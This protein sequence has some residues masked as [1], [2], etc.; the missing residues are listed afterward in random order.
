MAMMVSQS[1]GLSPEYQR[2]YDDQLLSYAKPQ[3]VTAQFAQ[4][5]PF[6]KNKGATSIRFF[7]PSAPDRTRVS[8]LTNEG[9]PLAQFSEIAYTGID[10]S[11]AQ[12]G[13][14]VKISDIVS[15]T[16]LF[17]TLDQSV[18]VMGE[19]AGVDADFR[20]ISQVVTGT[21]SA[22]KRYGSLAASNAAAGKLTIK[23][24]LASYTRLTVTKAKKPEGR[25]YAAILS[26]QQAYDIMDD[27]K[28]IDAGVRGNNKGLF[29]GEIGRWYGNRILVTTEPFIEAVGSE[30]TYNSAGA[31]YVAL[32]LGRESLG[33]CIMAGQSPFSPQIIVNDK[34]DSG[35]PLKQFMTAGWKAYWATVMLN[36]LWA[37]TLRSTST[38]A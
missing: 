12:Y 32:V 38:F 8:Q 37:V 18:R 28:F 26:P 17:D 19:D 9:V 35:N 24:L 25:E 21:N 16:D 34:A 36:D 13:E 1:S 10:V 14:A 6:P 5:K 23:D 3:I 31:M 7:R 20:C 15:Y 33:A 30:G 22:N 4:K 29:E 2:F 27:Q 11:M